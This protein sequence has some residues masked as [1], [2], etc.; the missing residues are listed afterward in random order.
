M[1]Y[2]KIL[3][4]VCLTAIPPTGYKVRRLKTKLNLPKHKI[5]TTS[6][7]ND[8]SEAQVVEMENHRLEEANGIDDSILE[9]VNAN[10]DGTKVD[11]VLAE[12]MNVKL[13]LRPQSSGDVPMDDVIQD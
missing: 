1:Y 6:M 3:Q 13:Q 7:D 10:G 11:E 4:F 12:Y 9:E 8:S 5:Q 2:I